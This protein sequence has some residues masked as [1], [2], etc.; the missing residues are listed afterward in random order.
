M[1][2]DVSFL[3]VINNFAGRKNFELAYIE[4]KYNYLGVLK[5]KK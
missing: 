1:G 5:I 2:E 4:Y 3:S